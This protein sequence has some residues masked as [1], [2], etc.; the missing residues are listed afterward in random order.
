MLHPVQLFFHSFGPDRI[1]DAK[2]SYPDAGSEVDV[3]F[4]VLVVEGR[5]LTFR[6]RHIKAPVGVGYILIIQF[7]CVHGSSSLSAAEHGA[8]TFIGKQ[9]H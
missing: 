8:H 2:G 4:A 5:A 9:L 1:V 3:F 6:Q 7:F